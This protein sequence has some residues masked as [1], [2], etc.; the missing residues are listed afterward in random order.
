[1]K[2]T[3]SIP[4]LV[5]SFVFMVLSLGPL[6]CEQKGGD[7]VTKAD[8]LDPGKTDEINVCA[9]YGEPPP[10]NCDICEKEGWYGDGTCDNNLI[11]RGY[12]IGPDPDCDTTQQGTF[13]ENVESWNGAP[14]HFPACLSE[15]S[16]NFDANNCEFFIDSFG[17]GEFSNSGPTYRWIQASLIVAPQDGLLQEAGMMVHTL[18]S[19]TGE[20]EKWYAVGTETSPSVYLLGFTYEQAGV[21]TGGFSY[22]VVDFAFFIDVKRATGEVVRLWVS[23]GGANYDLDQAY[24]VA[25]REEPLGGGTLEYA[26]GSVILFDQK[27][28]CE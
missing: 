15:V 5:L 20:I 26:D 8:L 19:D 7:E 22:E 25:G 4:L 13:C 12:C 24:A 2:K 28:A 27:R 21:S 23:D 16:M 6:G 10:P 18:N 3:A 11:S 9:S 1:M 17:R 14:N